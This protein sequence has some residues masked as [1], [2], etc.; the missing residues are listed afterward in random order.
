MFFRGESVHTESG[1]HARDALGPKKK[2]GQPSPKKPPPSY[3][4]RPNQCLNYCFEEM[5]RWVEV[6][7]DSKWIQPGS[8]S[9]SLSRL[10]VESQPF[11]HS[12]IMTQFNTHCLKICWTEVNWVV[13]TSKSASIPVLVF[14]WNW[15]NSIFSLNEAICF[16]VTDVHT[17]AY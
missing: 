13:M 8:L 3:L 2:Q 10:L 11:C 7:E 14:M 1:G 6:K 5:G 4:T 9:Q 17:Q 12:I 15:I 16:L